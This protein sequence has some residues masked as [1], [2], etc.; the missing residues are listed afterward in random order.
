MLVVHIKLWIRNQTLTAADRFALDTPF[1]LFQGYHTHDLQYCIPL[2]IYFGAS[3]ILKVM[4]IFD[5]NEVR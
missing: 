1:V 3:S 4:H 5:L 2:N